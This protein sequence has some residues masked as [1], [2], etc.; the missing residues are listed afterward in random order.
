MTRFFLYEGPDEKGKPT[1]LWVDL[2]VVVAI[3]L[4]ADEVYLEA[5]AHNFTFRPGSVDVDAL[6]EAWQSVRRGR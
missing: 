4:R 1:R 3:H 6:I 2:C 5:E